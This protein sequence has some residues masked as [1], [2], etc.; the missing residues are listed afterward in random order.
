[1]WLG[2]VVVTGRLHGTIV[3]PTGRPDPGYVRLVGQTKLKDKVTIAQYV[4]CGMVP[5]LLTSTD[6]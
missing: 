4:T 1:V 2:S 3:G 6:R 5:C